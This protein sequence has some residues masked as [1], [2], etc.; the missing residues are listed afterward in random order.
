[1]EREG[2]DGRGGGGGSRQ[3]KSCGVVQSVFVLQVWAHISTAA[4]AWSTCI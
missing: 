3:R 4:V 1:M 2:G